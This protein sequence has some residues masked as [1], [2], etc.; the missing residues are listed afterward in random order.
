M[1][2]K[3]FGAGHDMVKNL[4]IHVTNRS[5]FVMSVWMHAPPRYKCAWYTTASEDRY[6]FPVLVDKYIE[7]KFGVDLQILYM[8]SRQTLP[9]AFAFDP[10]KSRIA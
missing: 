5:C 7:E 8:S 4:Q 10:Q 6:S 2:T 9:F 1:A 3:P